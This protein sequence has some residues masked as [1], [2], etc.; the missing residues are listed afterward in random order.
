MPFVGN[1]GKVATQGFKLRKLL[2]LNLAFLLIFILIINAGI[3]MV[4]EGPEEGIKYIGNR[5]LS[6]TLGLQEDS[7]E[8]ISEESWWISDTDK[9]YVNLW[10][11]LKNTVSLLGYLITI[12]LWLNVLA[13]ISKK[14]IV[15]D[16]SKTTASWLIA[17]IMFLLIQ[18]VLLATLNDKSIVTPLLAF[19]DFGLALLYII[20]PLSRIADKFVGTGGENVSE[21]IN[22]TSNN[23]TNITNLV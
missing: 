21:V 23:V 15:Q 2:T 14:I 17:I 13:W 8:I 11:T 4:Q 18:M 16:D 22:V 3:I 19:R 20:P 7:Q 5:L 9:W 10:H 12:Y 1:V 6:P